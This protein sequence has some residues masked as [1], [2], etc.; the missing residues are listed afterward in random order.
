MESRKLRLLI[1]ATTAFTFFGTGTLSAKDKPRNWIR[2]TVLEQCRGHFKGQIPRPED[3]KSLLVEHKKWVDA[4]RGK[5][6]SPE[7]KADPRKANLCGADLSGLDL[8]GV[9]L[10]GADLSGAML[11]T[12]IF[13]GGRPAT[14]L[15]G[16]ILSYANLSGVRGV[17]VYLGDADLEGAD[18]SGAYLLGANL[19][20][21]KLGGASLNEANLTGANLAG[22]TFQPDDLP[23]ADDIA[24]A[25][26]L[27]RLQF[28][29]STQA[30]HKLRKVFNEGGYYRQEREVTYAIKHGEML[31]LL[32]LYGHGYGQTTVGESFEGLFQFIFFDLTCQWGMN[33]GRALLILLALIPIFAVPYIVA[34]RVPGENGIWRKWAK[35][36]LRAELGAEEPIRLEAG[37]GKATVLG[38]YFSIL[39]AFNIGW[40]EL[41]VGNWIQRLQ[42]NEYTLLASGWVRTVSGI[43]SLTSVYLLAIWVLTYF[44]RPFE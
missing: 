43:Q 12:R 33:P 29:T 26:N 7:A 8:G 13:K 28:Y 11:S 17:M 24:L 31:E 39:S 10:E 36:R 30:L 20:S 21:A 2:A 5:F 15:S 16:A 38:F 22:V 35:D 32:H 34:L 4:Y 44:G 37:W 9:N 40:R 23:D 25:D 27:S 1:A 14:N 18:L 6:D 3:L 42:A 19:R 41:N